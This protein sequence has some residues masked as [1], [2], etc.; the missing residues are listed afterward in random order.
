ME[1]DYWLPISLWFKRL[2][3]VVYNMWF[4]M[5]N[6]EHLY[7]FHATMCNHGLESFSRD[8]EW[9]LWGYNPLNFESVC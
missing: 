9:I 3:H 6:P 2:M 7:Y 5:Q 4:T 8:L 1:D